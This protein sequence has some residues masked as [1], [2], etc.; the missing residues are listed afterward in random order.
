MLTRHHDPFNKVRIVVIAGSKG[1]VAAGY[2]A[3]ASCNKGKAPLAVLLEPVQRTSAAG[4][5]LQI[6]SKGILAAG[7]VAAASRSKGCRAAGCVAIYVTEEVGIATGSEGI[8]ATGGVA[9]AA[10]SKGCRAAGYVAVPRSK[11]MTPLATLLSPP[12]QRSRLPLAIL[13]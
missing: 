8:V 10:R 5:G 6:R 4:F 11:G 1:I 12:P 9:T 2:V 7:V 13:L 3:I